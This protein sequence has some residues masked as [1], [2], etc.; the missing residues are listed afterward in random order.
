[1]F[2]DEESRIKSSRTKA[3]SLQI[4]LTTRTEA[5][6]GSRSRP[7]CSP[8]ASK[9]AETT[10]VAGALQR[11]CAI[12]AR[13]VDAK[14]LAFGRRALRDAVAVEK[15][16]TLGRNLRPRDAI[17]RAGRDAE[18][19]AR[20]WEP[21]RRTS[22]GQQKRRRMAGVD[23]VEG[24]RIVELAVDER[25]EARGQRRSA[26]DP[27][28][29]LDGRVDLQVLGDAHPQAHDDVARFERR[30]EDRGPRRRRASDPASTAR[31]RW[32]R[33]HPR[34]RH[35]RI[36]S[37]PP[38]RNPGTRE[39]GRAAGCAGSPG[40]ARADPSSRTRGRGAGWRAGPSGE[41]GSG[42]RPEA[43]RAG[44]SPATP[45]GR[46]RARAPQGRAPGKSRSAGRRTPPARRAPA[47]R[48]AR[49]A[50]AGRRSRASHGPPGGRA[51]FLRFRTPRRSVRARARARRGR[52]RRR[53]RRAGPR[54]PARSGDTA[55]WAPRRTTP[56]A[57]SDSGSRAS[58]LL[59]VSAEIA[60]EMRCMAGVKFA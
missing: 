7:A 18:Y 16:E 13:R 31:A 39:A 43:R 4:L 55:S 42:L 10:C 19:S 29:P 8:R 54:T 15:Q 48:D 33:R 32:R 27:V 35:P 50:P 44:R 41:A 12:P 14:L 59:R 30:R 49:G 5:S 53:R 58:F 2:S 9:I 40:R 52:S 38:A 17:G 11:T 37:A 23:V 47:G 57:T 6:S 28:E 1:M 21:V 20:E 25:D 45:R 60:A 22:P 51:P 34:P 26:E 3:K 46:P 56:P 36:P 24:S